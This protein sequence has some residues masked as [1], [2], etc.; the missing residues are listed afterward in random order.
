ML[1]GNTFSH[2]SGWLRL[3]S[4]VRGAVDV[5]HIDDVVVN[6]YV[7][8]TD[9]A[10]L[11]S[12]WTGQGWLRRV[13]AGAYVPAS[14]ESLGSENVLT[15]PWVL[16]PALYSPAYIGGWTAAH[17]WDLTEQLF[18]ET[19]VMTAQPVREKRRTRH[20]ADFVFSHIPA[21]KIFGTK[22]IWRGRSKI[23]ISDVHRISI[24]WTT[25]RWAVEFNIR[26]IA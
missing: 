19:L 10:K 24:C 23:A 1:V 2:P 7:S 4:V 8:R 12:R 5:I 21:A 22:S 3:A 16:V 20:S 14:L 15:D 13:G 25:H 9:A 11:L 6:L 17:H 26:R 18:R